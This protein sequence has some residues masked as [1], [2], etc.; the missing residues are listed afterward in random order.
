MP[1]EERTAAVNVTPTGQHIPLHL[2]N[3]LGVLIGG[4][5]VKG[6]R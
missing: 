4:G 5:G 2:D 3:P 6:I 1:F